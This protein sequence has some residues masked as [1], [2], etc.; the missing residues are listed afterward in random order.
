MSS[1][2]RN[3]GSFLYIRLAEGCGPRSSLATTKKF[4]ILNTKNIPGSIFLE[5]EVNKTCEFNSSMKQKEIL[6]TQFRYIQ[7]TLS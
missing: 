2:W 1:I 4:R 7:L 6:M 5:D 3:V